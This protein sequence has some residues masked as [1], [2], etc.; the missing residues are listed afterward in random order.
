MGDTKEFYIGTLNTMLEVAWCEG[1]KT[2]KLFDPA[3]AADQINSTY[4]TKSGWLIERK[5][6]ELAVGAV[7]GVLAFTSFDIAMRFTKKEDAVAMMT[8]LQASVFTNVDLFVTEH[9]WG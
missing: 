7:C 6:C 3:W 1:Q 8:V 4:E 9:Q 5:G 2:G